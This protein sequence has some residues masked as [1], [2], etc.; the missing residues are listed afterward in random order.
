MGN[1]GYVRREAVTIQMSLHVLSQ[2]LQAERSLP[3]SGL[4][5]KEV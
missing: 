4:P 2:Q 3:A 5:V 1:Q